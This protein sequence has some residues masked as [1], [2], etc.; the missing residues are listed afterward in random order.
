MLA[1]DVITKVRYSLSDLD[2]SNYR[3]SDD[4]LISLLNDVL[5]DLALTTKLYNKFSYLKL[6]KNETDYNINDIALKLLRVEYL[7]KKLDFVTHNEMDSCNLNWRNDTGPAP[8]KVIFTLSSGVGFTLYPKLDLGESLITENSLAGIITSIVY[9]DF[10]LI[11]ESNIGDISPLNLSNYIKLYYIAKPATVFKL[12][13]TLDTVV[14]SSMINALVK[15]IVGTALR[16]NIDANDRQ[17]GNED[18]MLY[19]NQKTSLLQNKS[20]NETSVVLE[21][22]YNGIG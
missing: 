8:T 19:Q 9:K 18:L 15:Y 17:M 2:S 16:D 21:T 4:R 12:T 5:L 11:L 14:E 3:W 7:D 1:S 10:K 13:D 20:I 6:I 22:K